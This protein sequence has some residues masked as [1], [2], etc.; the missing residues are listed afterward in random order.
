MHPP[1]SFVE[2]NSRNRSYLSL[3]FDA[4]EVA[5]NPTSSTIRSTPIILQIFTTRITRGVRSSH[6]GHIYLTPDEIDYY[7]ESLTVYFTNKGSKVQSLLCPDIDTY[8]VQYNLNMVTITFVSN[9]PPHIIDQV[10]WRRH[11]QVN[12]NI[13]P[14]WEWL[15]EEGHI[16]TNNILPAWSISSNNIPPLSS[17][18]ISESMP[19]N[20]LSNNH[21]PDPEDS[22]SISSV[23]FS[24]MGMHGRKMGGRFMGSQRIG[25]RTYP[26][27]PHSFN[28]NNS[29]AVDLSLSVGGISS[30]FNLGILHTI[31]KHLVLQDTR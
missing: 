3:S 10:K 1:S 9:L 17:S 15:P 7:Q 24:D 28:H 25:G 6:Q 11:A 29:N 5:T 4:D 26:H 19:S 8:L 14:S 16:H 13:L 23:N 2:E 27:M 30:P 18:S 31:I 22:I 12:K 20:A 21:C